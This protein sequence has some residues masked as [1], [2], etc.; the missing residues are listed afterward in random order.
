LFEKKNVEYTNN[1]GGD[2]TLNRRDLRRSQGLVAALITDT[3]KAP[4]RVIL[5]RSVRRL[6]PGKD[7]SPE[8]GSQIL[9]PVMG[10]ARPR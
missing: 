6:R 9:K 3:D 1:S 7:R 5:W 8:F 10:A 2:R 4:G